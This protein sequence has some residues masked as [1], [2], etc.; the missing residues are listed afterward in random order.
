MAGMLGEEILLQHETKLCVRNSRLYN[1]EI[2]LLVSQL[3]GA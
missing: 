2:C 3:L 1:A